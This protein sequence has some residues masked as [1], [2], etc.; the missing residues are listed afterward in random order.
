[1]AIEF[2]AHRPSGTMLVLGGGMA[3]L[4]AGLAA[5]QA[6][7]PGTRVIILEADA[8]PGGS[9]R[10]SSGRIWTLP[11]YGA[12]RAA[13]PLGDAALQRAL[14]DG[15]DDA[16]D[17][18]AA[19]IGHLAPQPAGKS[20]RGRSMQLG[21]TGDRGAFFAAFASGVA[22]AGVDIR[23]GAT[24]EAVRRDSGGQLLL[25][26][27][28]G[29]TISASALVIA[30]GGF[31][32]DREALTHWLG[33][34][35]SRLMLRSNPFSRGAGLRIGTSLGGV[36]SR[37]MGQFY[38]KSMPPGSERLD[39][40][41]YK[42][43]TYDVARDAIAVNIEGRRFVDEASGISS[44]A[45]ANAGLYQPGD[46]YALLLDGAQ[47]GSVDLTALGNHAAAT[48]QQ[49]ADLMLEA[50]TLE[51][52]GAMMAR[53]WGYDASGV[54][55]TVV[56]VN[57]DMPDASLN[58][59][60]PPRRGRHGGLRQPPFRALRCRPAITIPLGG[61]KVDAAMSLCDGTGRPVPGVHV[62]GADAGGV[63]LGAYAG[64]LAWALVSGKI[65]GEAAAASIGAT[66]Q[67]AQ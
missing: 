48:G 53:R 40:R 7:D 60:T 33:P 28:N 10:W 37:G 42:A 30:T 38:G 59:L 54:A 51:A 11:D 50:E 58:Q 20:G 22:S 64:G 61:L 47:A 12:L 34:E 17:W 35:A 46:S 32:G 31:Q 3:G 1:M 52:L 21:T 19:G 2:A 44:E 26:T 24:V 56:S 49:M 4:S 63:Y 5:A 27:G 16:L 45:V 62:A 25:T 9:A 23:Y 29:L 43:L 18:L 15:L 14:S 8:R 36:T 57:S 41:L 65:A 39:P 66:R 13:S 55:R 6:A 67:A